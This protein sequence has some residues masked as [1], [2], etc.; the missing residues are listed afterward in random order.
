MKWH[1]TKNTLPPTLV[2]VLGWD[3]RRGFSIC[4]WIDR[5]DCERGQ[6]WVVNGSSG[7]IGTKLEVKPP[8]YW[9]ELPASPLNAA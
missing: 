3:G 4:L 2:E 1:K 7:G 9:H 8:T 6:Y 5:G